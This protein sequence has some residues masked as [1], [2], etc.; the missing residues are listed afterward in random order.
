MIKLAE[1]LT[2]NIEYFK[3]KISKDPI[4]PNFLIVKIKYP[5][6]AGGALV[7]LG[8][9]T[10]SG[11]QREEGARK[12]L[13]IGNQIA[14]EL[15]AEYDLED[16]E[17]TDLENGTVQVF[18]VSDD[19]INK[20]MSEKLDP[21]GKEDDDINNDGKVDKTDK[22]LA[23][24]RKAIA[25]NIKENEDHEASMAKG[26]LRDMLMNGAKLYQMI[27]PG[28]NLPGWVSSYITLASDYIHSVSEYMTEKSAEEE[29]E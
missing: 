8:S 17:V 1:L 9:K 13:A 23:N 20:A 3:P 14:D 10:A 12:A 29:Y 25:K 27:K 5:V 4:H 7:A 24:R 22:Y 21:V 18:A 28:E 6:G 16:I 15:Q 11:Q 19:F 26:E 2:E